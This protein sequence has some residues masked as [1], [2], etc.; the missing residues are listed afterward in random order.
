MF[1]LWNII[2]YFNNNYIFNDFIMI[3]FSD[4]SGE[5]LGFQAVL[6]ISYHDGHCAELVM[7]ALQYEV[8]WQ[9]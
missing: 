2:A 3:I 7:L 5:R 9:Y 6:V 4:E 1:E 8:V